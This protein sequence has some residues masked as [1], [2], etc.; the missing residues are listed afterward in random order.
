M[1]QRYEKF[2]KE[3]LEP[4][5]EKYFEEQCEFVKC[6]EGCSSC[7]EVGE[8]PFSRLELEYLM[9]GFEIGRAHV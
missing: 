2:L 7:C 1:L 9:S 4:K 6:K 3:V 5:L 8:Y